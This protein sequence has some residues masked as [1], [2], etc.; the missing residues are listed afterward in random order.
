MAPIK[1]KNIHSSSFE[2]TRSGWN[3]A[4]ASRPL[5]QPPACAVDHAQYPAPAQTLWRESMRRR[6]PAAH[7]SYKWQME[8]FATQHP[9][10]LKR[11]GAN[12]KYIATAAVAAT[13]GMEICRRIVR[14]KSAEDSAERGRKS[15]MYGVRQ[16]Q[17][18]QRAAHRSRALH[19][20]PAPA[21]STAQWPLHDATEH[22]D[23]A[24]PSKIAAYPCPR[25]SASSCND[26]G[27]SCGS[28]QALPPVSL[29][30]AGAARAAHRA[31]TIAPQLR[32]FS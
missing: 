3:P 6:K 17:Q 16:P 23:R 21:N 1:V 12:R 2:H 14:E 27:H 29:P 22:T 32:S 4:R 24:A 15:S 7:K 5:H 19:K 26:A 18:P 20:S 9:L 10:H 31:A 28:M 13:A 11:T 25:P 8:S 30:A